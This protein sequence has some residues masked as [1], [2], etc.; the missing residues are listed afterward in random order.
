M[1]DEVLVRVE[2]VGKKF[3]R[4]MKQSLWYGMKDIAAELLPGE[5]DLERHATLRPGEFWA[6][7][8]VSFELRRGECLGLI[9]RNGAGKTTL[10]KMLNGL[11]KPDKGR[12]EIRGRV[13]ALIALGAGFNPVLTGRENVYVNGSVLGLSKNEIDVKFDEIVE[14]AELGAFIDTP[15]QSYSSGMVVRL[16]F[17][18]ASILSPDILI[19]DEVLAVGDVA[20]QAKCL[21]ALA[22]LRATGVAFILVSHN[23]HQISRYAPSALYL[24]NGRLNYSGNAETAISRLL[25]ENQK[26]HFD[27]SITEHGET[28]ALGSGKVVFTRVS[29]HDHEDRPVNVINAGDPLTLKIAYEC[30]SALQS[31]PVLDVIVRS[32]DGMVFQGTNFSA[33]QPFETFPR[34]GE[35]AVK[36]LS[37]PINTGDVEFSFCLLDKATA[38]VFDWKRQLRLSIR[39]NPTSNGPLALKTIWLVG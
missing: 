1:N 5:R 30:R 18:T 27:I 3:C 26:D 17:A 8:D 23:M 9:G 28:R 11:I 21:N 15:V 29:F 36:F 2:G 7:E 22:E 14:F 10:L 12:I 4:D 16:G 20:F 33:G 31:P 24:R 38:E 35:L 13:G 37:L 32:C 39:T 19:L 6:V 34:Q 25:A